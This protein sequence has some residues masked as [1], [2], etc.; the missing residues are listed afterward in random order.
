M[1]RKNAGTRSNDELAQ[2]R[3]L[4]AQVGE[5]HPK[6]VARRDALKAELAEVE[7][8]LGRLQGVGAAAGAPRA[9]TASPPSARAAK[10]KPGRPRGKRTGG[11]SLGQIVLEALAK[12]GLS[13]SKLYE[14]VVARRPGTGRNHLAT[15]LFQLGRKGAIKRSGKRGS[16]TYSV[17]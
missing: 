5:L 6:L 16:Y 3:V 10:R 1:P 12:G 17:A 8:L 15:E 13:A 14:A 2:A 11:P 4:F 7:G 9:A